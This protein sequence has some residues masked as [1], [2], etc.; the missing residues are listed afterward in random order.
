VLI[1]TRTGAT[2]VACEA[3]GWSAGLSEPN[4]SDITSGADIWFQYKI[5]FTAT[6]STVLNPRVYFTNGHVV[7][8]TYTQR[9]N[10][11]DDTVEF[12]Y[13]I[14]IRNFD[15]P[16]VDKIFKKIVTRHDADLGS[17]QVKW[18]TET[19]SGSFVVDLGAKPERWD[20]FFPSD[21]LGQEMHLEI[22]K[23]DSYD[24]MLKEL[25]LLYTPEPILI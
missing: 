12:R 5:E 22:Y 19:S 24:F 9:V 1:H 2:Q 4:G 10:D 25:K 17:F 14:G 8:Y 18:E 6:D 3:A 15:E 16:M 23:N 11:V 20:S 21:A 7:R 13:K